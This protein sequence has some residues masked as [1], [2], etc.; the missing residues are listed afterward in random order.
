MEI[1]ELRSFVAI[2]HHENMTK[3]AEE[4]HVS[5]SA[6]SKQVKSLEKELGCSLFNRR[7]FGLDLTEEGRLLQERAMSLVAMANK[8]EDEFDALDSI[9]GGKL[10]FGLAESFQVKYLAREIKRLKESCP[11]LEYHV[12]SGVSAQVLGLLDG[13]VI[14]FAVLAEEPDVSKY[15]CIEFPERERWGIVMATGCELAKKKSVTI[16]DL[17]GL[18]LFCSDQAWRN[19]IPQWAG[20]RNMEK[21]HR[22]AGFGLAY[23]G[24]VFARE[25]LGYLF[26]LDKIVDTSRGSGVVFRPLSPSLRTKLY[27]V[28]RAERPLTPIAKRFLSQV[29]EAFRTSKA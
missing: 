19:D 18:P 14:D 16:D 27:F 22:A 6:L 24:A 11:E 28:W 29:K 23:N 10:Y 25:G 1:R 9:T 2:A 4:L 5:Q 26:A 15:G 20:K 21:L 8:I 13:G 17:I 12:V 7:S 3:A